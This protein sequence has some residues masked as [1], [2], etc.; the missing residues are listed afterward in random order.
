MKSGQV[1]ATL[2]FALP[3]QRSKGQNSI[4]ARR[5]M[6]PGLC[7]SH[8]DVAVPFGP[9]S[10][11]AASSGSAAGRGSRY[12]SLPRS[13]VLVASTSSLLSI[14]GAAHGRRRAR[15]ARGAQPGQSPW[16]RET[17]YGQA[18]VRS[19]NT[20][21]DGAVCLPEGKCPEPEPENEVQLTKM[22]CTLG[23]SSKDTDVI[24]QLIED[25]MS[26]ARLNFSH[27]THE[28]Q[29][30]ILNKVRLAAEKCSDYG[31]S[32]ATM[33][34]TK[35]PEIRTG[36]TESGTKVSY[37]RGDQITVTND[38]EALCTNSV[39]S[40]SY[41]DFPKV[42]K[43]GQP[44]RIG[45]GT[46]NLEVTNVDDAAH[47]RVRAR[48]ESDAEIGERKNCNI[49]GVRVDLP[50]LS[51]QDKDDLLSF[52]IPHKVDFVALSFVQD[53]ESVEQVR[54]MLKEA[55]PDGQQP[56]LLISKIENGEGLTNFDEILE[57]SDGIM[58]ARG[59]L[60]MEIPPE[61]VFMAQKV[62]IGRTNL[63]GKF[64]ITATQMLE[65]MTKSPRPTRAEA[66]DVANAVLDGTDCVMLSGETAAG[67]FPNKAARMMS[68]IC[69]E[70][71]RSMDHVMNYE[72]VSSA[73]EGY[74]READ[75]GLCH[76]AVRLAID[77]KATAI[78]AFTESGYSARQ[79]SKFKPGVPIIAVTPADGALSR[80]LAVV[81]GVVSIPRSRDFDVEELGERLVE[82]TD[83]A[84]EDAQDRGWVVSGDTV[85]VVG[86]AQGA[87]T[88]S[89]TNRSGFSN[90]VK[91][92]TV[93]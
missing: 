78:L 93:E 70:A 92:V 71:E 50:L 17:R 39:L 19:R 49:P 74:V 76:A 62:M 84:L 2:A 64:V 45:D 27:G 83:A 29:L 5:W 77:T 26:V 16:A 34:D 73:L 42:V 14:V 22:I 91:C 56:P 13:A 58:V 81:R 89:G 30:E 80:K 87:R 55:C 21:P 48:V 1:P 10:T 88:Q 3:L 57:A 31:F 25:G 68:R 47:G 67:L 41:A 65:S 40:L 36:L 59:D 38:Y 52:A 51:E 46:L 72:R 23:P 18:M 4:L 7:T 53:G 44:I 54:Q 35:G 90:I 69:C 63:A 24:K 86:C 9:V 20:C 15:I 11:G 79:L 32:V 12:D 61:Q 82:L 37:R 8:S 75:E 60:G 33:L 6:T 85:V 66:S 43:V 28:S